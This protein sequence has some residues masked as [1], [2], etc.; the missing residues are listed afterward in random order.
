MVV[1]LARRRLEV[2]EGGWGRVLTLSQTC[3]CLALFTTVLGDPSPPGL[4]VAA[5]A[6]RGDLGPSAPGEAGDAPTGAGAPGMTG[7]ASS[8]DPKLWVFIMLVHGVSLRKRGLFSAPMSSDGASNG[9]LVGRLQSLAER[10]LLGSVFP[11]ASLC[12]PPLRS[13]RRRCGSPRVDGLLSSET[14]PA[15]GDRLGYPQQFFRS[16]FRSQPREFSRARA[17]ALAGAR[18]DR[19]R[20]GPPRAPTSAPPPLRSN[21]APTALS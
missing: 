17:R 18:L 2:G 21:A 3:I 5:A 20:D 11:L 1:A 4:V 8:V 13:G 7:G 16:F 12:L 10:A 9:K 6:F 14:F 19:A 15:L